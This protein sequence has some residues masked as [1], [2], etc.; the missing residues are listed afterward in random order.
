MVEFTLIEFLSRYSGDANNVK[1]YECRHSII[2]D[3]APYPWPDED[4]VASSPN[5]GAYLDRMIQR[6]EVVGGCLCAVVGYIRGDY[7]NHY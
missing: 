4:L 3:G 2:G 7:E 5:I 6:W 1:L